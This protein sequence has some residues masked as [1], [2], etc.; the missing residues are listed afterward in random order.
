MNH[1]LVD[2]NNGVIRHSLRERKKLQTHAHLQQQALRLF[3]EQGYAA[4]TT[5]Q[6]A[7]AAGVSI[8]T[9]FRY[10]PTKEDLV[11]YDHTNFLMAELFETQPPELNPIQ[12]SKSAFKSTMQALSDNEQGLQELRYRLIAATPTLRS[13]MVD[14][15]LSHTPVLA[16]AIARR[17]GRGENDAEVLALAGAYIGIS[18]SVF[19]QVTEQKNGTLKSY[20]E[21]VGRV[22]DGLK[23]TQI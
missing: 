3:E 14:N 20:I 18:L 4:T 7:E 17:T 11:L 5:L 1:K 13:R 8:G 2:S 16:R 10:F 19:V 22:L 15:V 21:Q 9:L 23:A 6:I 12:A